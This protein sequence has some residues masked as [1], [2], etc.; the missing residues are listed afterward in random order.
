MSPLSTPV[1]RTM[2]ALALSV[3]L[4][5]TGCATSGDSDSAASSGGIPESTTGAGS[6]NTAEVVE[7]ANAFLDLLSDDQRASVVYDYDD[8]AKT[9]GW[10][11]FPT[12]F[13]ERSGV[14][15]ADFDDEQK[16]AVLAVMEAALSEHGYQ[17]LEEIRVADAVL[18]AEQ[19][20]SGDTD[21]PGGPAT[22]D[23]DAYYIAFYGEPSESAQFMVQFGG[24]HAAYNITYAGDDVSLSPT[25]TAIEPMEFE[26]EGTSYAPLEDSRSTTMAVIDSLSEEEL[27]AAEIGESY[28]DLLLGPENDGPFPDPEGVLVSDLTQEQQDLVTEM[29]RTWVTDLDEEAAEALMDKYVAEYDETYVGWSDATALDDPETYVRLDGPSA[30]VEFS[31]QPDR[32]DEENIHQHTIFRDETADYGWN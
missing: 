29:L 20:E 14:A 8:E 21:G 28:D 6:A 27:A 17:E 16:A 13:V 9:T 24:H 23:P 18:G 15:L 12:S 19:E 32:E 11:N 26:Y 10:S 4:V 3:G 1:H 5:A 31:N 7:A 25:L 22:F 30:W 2:A